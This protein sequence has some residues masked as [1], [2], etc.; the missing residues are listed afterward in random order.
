[1]S[2]LLLVCLLAGAA[3]GAAPFVWRLR[4]HVA[5]FAAAVIPI[6]I[7]IIWYEAMAAENDWEGHGALALAIG[8]LIWMIL[9]VIAGLLSRWI[10]RS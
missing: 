2:V 6:V 9:A 1:M 3:G 10:A 8:A 4:P 7:T 5:I